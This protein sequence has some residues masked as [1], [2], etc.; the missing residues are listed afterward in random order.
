MNVWGYHAVNLAIHVLAAWTLF[1]VTRRT[2][3]LPPLHYRFGLAATPL[4]LAVAMLWTLHPLQTEA[5]TY[6]IQRTEALAGLFYLLVLY[7]VVRGAMS[8][9]SIFWYIA[10]T[11]SC[12][13]GM[14]TKEVMATAPLLV[15]LYDRTFLAGS[16]REALRRRFG[17]YLA[18]AATW[19]V[20]PALLF[21]TGF[22]G[23]TAGFAVQKFTWWSYLLTQ[24]GVIVHYLRLAFWPL[25]CVSTTAGLPRTDCAD[26]AAARNRRRRPACSDRLGARKAA[27]MGVR[28][29]VVLRDPRAVVEFRAHQRCGVRASHVSCR[30]RRWS[31]AW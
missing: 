5:V 22:Y 23:G 15:L 6:V 8:T 10:A 17:L 14:A 9:R 28:R 16:F 31:W 1:G 2:L 13:L 24:S 26:R 7:C 4:A 19:T 12:L 3:L 29:R 11:V 27:R 30:W 18:L 25:G 20:V 21:S